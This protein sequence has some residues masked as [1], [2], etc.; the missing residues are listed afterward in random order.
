[1][2]DEVI[3]NER[4]SGEVNRFATDFSLLEAQVRS[5]YD[6]ECDVTANLANVSALLFDVLPAVN[7]AGFYRLMP[8]GSLMLAPFQGKPA[9][10]R[11]A[12]G[13]GVCGAAVSSG[14]TVV[15]RDVHEFPGHIACDSAS[16]SEIVVP[17]RLPGGNIWGVLDIDS[18][19]TGRFGETER[20]GLENVGKII[21]NY[22][23]IG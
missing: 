9:C 5:L 6:D 20:E 15:V 19:V 18:P 10:M 12:A 22:F 17:I 13:K 16:A 4:N 2:S 7:W 23:E 1:M 3:I 8:D 21:E 14:R 11:L